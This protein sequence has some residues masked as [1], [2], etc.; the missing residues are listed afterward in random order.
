MGT[1]LVL[2]GTT[3]GIV[4]AV[5]VASMISINRPASASHVFQE[6]E[7]R[8]TR[9]PT[10]TPTPAPTSQPQSQ[11]VDRH[12]AQEFSGP[13]L[14]VF[15]R[16]HNAHVSGRIHDALDG[17]EEL[18]VQLPQPS[19]L[20]ENRTGRIFQSMGLHAL[21]ASY[22]TRAVDAGDGPAPRWNRA[23]AL[24]DDHR[25]ESAV[26]DAEWLLDRGDYPIG[27][28]GT[29]WAS[30][31]E[32]A[33]THLAAHYVISRCHEPNVAVA[34]WKREKP[35]EIE[36][37]GEI[38]LLVD[39]TGEPT[40]DGNVA[41]DESVVRVSPCGSWFWHWT[42]HQM[43]MPL[44]IRPSETEAEDLADVWQPVV[45]PHRA[46]TDG[47]PRQ[48]GPHH[49]CRNQW[50]SDERR[51]EFQMHAGEGLK[52]AKSGGMRECHEFDETRLGPYGCPFLR[53]YF[54]DAVRAGEVMEVYK[55]P[56]RR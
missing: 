14:A 38:L 51:E 33:T 3:M 16:A 29:T 5:L 40:V 46:R 44:S 24:L 39:S 19:A 20:V 43:P 37:E 42:P 34:W 49:P 8:P 12:F 2:C 10:L 25:C 26:E 22:F 11:R 21:A 48:T 35:K 18:R 31:G 55:P 27:T 17:Y 7:P 28:E 50:S 56:T 1:R 6:T 45:E 47:H 52:L 4:V 53:R 36:I 13:H 9:G 23:K 32:D 54:E 15:R 41:D 30:V